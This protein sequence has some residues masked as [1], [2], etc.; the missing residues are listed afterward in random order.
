[1]LKLYKITRRDLIILLLIIFTATLMRFGAPGVSDFFHDDAMVSSMAQD[2]VDGEIFPLTGILSSVGIPN[3]PTSIYVMALPYSVSNHPQVA[4]L[5]I[6]LLNVITVGL[7][8]VF[9][10][11]YF[12]RTVGLVAGLAYALNPWAILYSRKIWAQ[13]YHTP[14]ILFGLMLA[15]YGF[16]ERSDDSRSLWN[17]RYT[18]AQI[19]ALPVLLFGMQI[20]FA[21]WALLPIYGLILWM[22]RQRIDWRAVIISLLLG[23][24]VMMPYAIGLKQ[25]L[26]KDPTRISDTLAR[27]EASEGLSL[28]T[29]PL[30]SIAY[31]TTGTGVETWV[32]PDQTG[33]LLKQVPP[34]TPLWMLLGFATL[35]GIPALWTIQ[36]RPLRVV[37]LMWVIF[38]VIVFTPSW[39]PV[40]P[41][42][43]V[44]SIPALM[45][46]IGVGLYWLT[47]RLPMRRH[48]H[49]VAL[50]FLTIILLTQGLWWRGLIRY[51]DETEIAYPGFTTPLH[52]LDDVR[53][54]LTQYDDVVVIS[55]GMSWLLH[56]ESVVWPVMLEDSVQCVRTITSEE[57]AVFP[58][59][60][61]A[62]LVAPDAPPGLSRDTLY[63]TPNLD[64]YP[65]R[66]GGGEYEIHSFQQ[67]PKWDETPII[68]LEPVIFEGGV[69]LTGYYL[70]QD[71]LVLQWQLPSPQPGLDYQYS[72]QF[73]DANGERLGQQDRVFWHGR[74]WCAGDTLIT[75]TSINLPENTETLR[76]SLYT[77]GT[78]RTAGQYFSAN[79]LDELGNPA[80]QWTDIALN[81]GTGKTGEP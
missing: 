38:P 52:Y 42:Y 29:D 27:S 67:P 25:T 34:L 53:E 50:S 43:F 20:H 51:L 28:T 62:I 73:L 71:R 64:K 69:Q 19:L 46:L 12:G 3:P 66:D 16:W 21:G 24:L 9:A 18:W 32:A 48:S 17:N 41:H 6:M 63:Q 65:T 30:V 13:D 4:I 44:T 75:W 68:E 57:Y 70:E 58:D 10:H 33:D 36:N 49:T 45:I 80:G 14:F 47:E 55:H 39:T 22:G 23:A 81:M 76:V 2:M 61:F 1:M 77:L 7:L 40:Y 74:H 26:D 37:L 56:H 54:S 5:F 15:F 78:G 59:G 8:W 11:R 60:P 35:M 31:L 79:I 72:G